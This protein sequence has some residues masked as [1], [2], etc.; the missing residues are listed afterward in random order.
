MSSKPHSVSSK[1]P[2]PKAPTPPNTIDLTPG[3]KGATMPSPMSPD[4]GVFFLHSSYL[5][6]SLQKGPVKVLKHD[7]AVAPLD[8]VLP[9][10]AALEK[11]LSLDAVT[12]TTAAAAENTGDHS[13]VTSSSEI[14]QSPDTKSDVQP[15]GEDGQQNELKVSADK[16]DSSGLSHGN[17]G[18]KNDDAI[19][20]TQ[21]CSSN[22]SATAISI[23][24]VTSRSD[25]N[26]SASSNKQ[27]DRKS[28]LKPTCPPFETYKFVARVSEPDVTS[29]VTEISLG[30]NCTPADSEL[31]GSA[32][33]GAKAATADR[34]NL[35]SADVIK[36]SDATSEVSTACSSTDSDTAELQIDEDAVNRVSPGGLDTAT[37]SKTDETTSQELAVVT[38]SSA[39]DVTPET[40]DSKSHS[41]PVTPTRSGRHRDVVKQSDTPTSSRSRRS[42][43]DLNASIDSDKTIDAENVSFFEANM[44]SSTD[45]SECRDDEIDDDHVEP[46]IRDVTIAEDDPAAKRQL[47]MTPDIVSSP[48]TVADTSSSSSEALAL[49]HL[50]MSGQHPAVPAFAKQNVTQASIVK[51]MTGVRPSPIPISLPPFETLCSRQA[52]SATKSDVVGPVARSS[53]VAMIEVPA[54]TAGSNVTATSVVA[55]NAEQLSTEK[56]DAKVAAVGVSR[57]EKIV[58]Q[59]KRT[60]TGS[61]E[62]Q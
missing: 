33:A 18:A 58:S 8:I 37:V 54:P 16:Q 9:S 42:D 52:V 5:P 34:I 25:D 50:G 4:V 20:S 61:A 12:V 15:K 17:V 40:S 11:Q 19:G 26:Q 43:V 31:N 62:S 44:S 10:D 47:I 45:D 53:P 57:I 21:E 23:S 38:A 46:V 30:G 6:P 3:R 7:T 24:M 49:D 14:T 51:S 59:I 41:L 36:S 1:S 28:E 13:H 39:S 48:N 60:S 35:S 56:Q 2:S 55:T 22:P 29:S 32:C 27:C